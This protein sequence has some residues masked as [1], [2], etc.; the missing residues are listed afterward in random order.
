MGAALC[1][2][3]WIRLFGEG[4]GVVVCVVAGGAGH[5]GGA[6]LFPHWH[7][8]SDVPVIAWLHGTSYFTSQFSSCSSAALMQTCPKL[9][10]YRSQRPPY[11]SART[12]A[13]QFPHVTPLSTSAETPWSKLDAKTQNISREVRG[14]V[15]IRAKHPKVVSKTPCIFMSWVRLQFWNLS[16]RVWPAIEVCATFRL[17]LWWARPITRRLIDL[18]DGRV[19]LLWRW[20][21]LQLPQAVLCNCWIESSFSQEI[22]YTIAHCYHML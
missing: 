8:I 17:W 9:S 16:S 13:M 12:R 2:T 6:F 4:V 1:P 10:Q 19:G 18:N 20:R 7:K 15:M 22:D 11:F 14:Q 21:N 3:T 5:W